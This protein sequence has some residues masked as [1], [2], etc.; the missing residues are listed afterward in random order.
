MILSEAGGP[1]PLSVFSSVFFLDPFITIPSPSYPWAATE[2]Q[3]SSDFVSI[4]LGFVCAIGKD[5][6]ELDNVL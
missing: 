2:G 5:K 1:Q 6:V 3:L 4:S